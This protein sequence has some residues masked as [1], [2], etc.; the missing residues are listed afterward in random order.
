MGGI[1]TYTVQAAMALAQAGHEPHIFTLTLPIDVLKN[2]PEGVWVHEIADL[3]AEATQASVTREHARHVAALDAF[4]ADAVKRGLVLTA[5]AL[6][7]F[8]TRCRRGDSNPHG[9]TPTAP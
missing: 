4:D 1:G 5:V 2:L 8:V 7:V 6:V 9:R 3:A